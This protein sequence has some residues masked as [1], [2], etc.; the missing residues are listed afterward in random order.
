MDKSG[1]SMV[2][3]PLDKR[4]AIGSTPIR[5]TVVAPNLLHY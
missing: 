2:E 4:M 5:A 3:H 1:S